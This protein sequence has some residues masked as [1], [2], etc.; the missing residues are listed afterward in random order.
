[1][2]FYTDID[3]SVVRVDVLVS[4]DVMRDCIRKGIPFILMAARS[5]SPACV[6]SNYQCKDQDP[7]R[8]FVR[9]EFR[10][11]LKAEQEHIP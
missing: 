1:M 9:I 3:E 7:I 8:D 4:G 2:S 5:L 10:G 11:R 6:W